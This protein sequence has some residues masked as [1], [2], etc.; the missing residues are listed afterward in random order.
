MSHQEISSIKLEVLIQNLVV[1]VLQS[2]GFVKF[3]PLLVLT[4]INV[5]SYT[6]MIKNLSKLN[7]YSLN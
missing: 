1:Q 4:V 2:R 5:L 6:I 3:R 7:V